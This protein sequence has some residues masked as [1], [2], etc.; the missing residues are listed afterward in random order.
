MRKI[1]RSAALFAAALATTTGVVTAGAS[2]ANASI[3]P[4][5]ASCNRFT[6][7]G[8]TFSVCIEKIGTGKVQAKIGSISG[9]Y[10]SGS[11]TVY[12]NSSPVQESCSGQHRPGD[13]CVFNYTGGAGR[14]RS[15]WNGTFSSPTISA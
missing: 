1:A 2:T 15:A 5:A 4:A 11:L 8:V 14:Y 10:V 6:S 12:K 9:T 7:G 13:S 3:T